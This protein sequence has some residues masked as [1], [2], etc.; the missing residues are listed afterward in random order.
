MVCRADTTPTARSCTFDTAHDVHNQ[1]QRTGRAS[2]A[3]HPIHSTHPHGR[4]L[5][6]MG[7]TQQDQG[8][9]DAILDDLACMLGCTRTSLHGMCAGGVGV[10]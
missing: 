6:P 7:C 2:S 3:P 9:S 10:A 1:L 5:T 4:P 8:Q